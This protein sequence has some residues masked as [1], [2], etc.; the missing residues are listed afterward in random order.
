M[1]VFQWISWL[2]SEAG[3][4]L[5]LN[6]G[7]HD[8][9]IIHRRAADVHELVSVHL[10]SEHHWNDH[11]VSSG[12]TARTHHSPVR[13]VAKGGMPGPYKMPPLWQH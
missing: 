10:I 11:S 6:S 13:S 9:R 12:S 5:G 4:H 8:I 3:A 1:V 2:Q 7:K